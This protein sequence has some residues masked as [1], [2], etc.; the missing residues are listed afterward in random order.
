M[1][2]VERLKENLEIA[3]LELKEAEEKVVIADKLWWD[4]R[5][6]EAKHAIIVL[7]KYL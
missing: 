7:P 1:S 2:E 3:V 4:A 5:V 6:A